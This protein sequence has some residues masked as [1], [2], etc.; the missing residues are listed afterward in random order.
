MEIDI[1]AHFMAQQQA[2][3]AQSILELLH[4]HLS[5]AIYLM[6]IDREQKVARRSTSKGKQA[7]WHHI[8]NIYPTR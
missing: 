3:R 4:P 2:L 7:I 5:E 6:T 1:L 8:F